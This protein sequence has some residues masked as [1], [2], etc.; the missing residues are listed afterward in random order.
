MRRPKGQ[1]WTHDPHCDQVMDGEEKPPDMDGRKVTI[2][3]SVVAWV[4]RVS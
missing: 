4:R 3:P 2:S 1:T